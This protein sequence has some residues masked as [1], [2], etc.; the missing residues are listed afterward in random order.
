MN[1]DMDSRCYGGMRDTPGERRLRWLP[2]A[3]SDS[4]ASRPFVKTPRSFVL[5]A[6]LLGALL[7]GGCATP[8]PVTDR[9][10]HQEYVEL[11]DP[12]EPANR[13]IFQFN[14]ALDKGL[15]Q[16]VAR[17]YR[18]VIPLWFRQRIG[19]AL[20]NLRAPV[21]FLNDVLQGEP[22]RAQITLVRFVMNSTFGIAGLAD[23]AGEAGIEGH[24]EDFGQTL[25]VWGTNDG[26]YIMLPILGPSNPRDTVGMVVDWLVDPFNN[27]T[28]NTD[29][30]ELALARTG[31]AALHLRT[32][33]LPVTDELEKTS[34]DLYAAVRSL[35]RQRR[36]DAITNGAGAKSGPK[37][38][39]MD[40][41]S[42]TEDGTGQ[43][44]SRK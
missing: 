17:L 22:E 24:D 44:S 26:P 10:A 19:D 7:T 41:P 28:R 29:R 30:E 21:V 32:E 42:F 16:P 37:L 27:W 12:M 20:D 25:A 15:F 35:Y 34:L 4:R 33:L 3:P 1:K 13:A 38:S 36:A 31:V 6:V 40:F 18:D 5:A 23:F 39:G 14:Q 8:P 43:L 9:E 11:N 2:A